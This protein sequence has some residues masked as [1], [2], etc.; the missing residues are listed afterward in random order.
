MLVEGRGSLLYYLEYVRKKRRRGQKRFEEEGRTCGNER[1]RRD[2]ERVEHLHTAQT[3]S[4]LENTDT[5]Q[6]HPCSHDD[7]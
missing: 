7:Q 4:D 6:Y 2:G 5:Q 3:Q 1:Q